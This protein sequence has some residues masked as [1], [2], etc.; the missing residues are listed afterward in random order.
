MPAI[1]SKLCKMTNRC[2][3]NVKSAVTGLLVKYEMVGFDAN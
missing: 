1:T 3:I 2:T